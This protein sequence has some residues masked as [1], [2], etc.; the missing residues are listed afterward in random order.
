VSGYR[1][2]RAS[3]PRSKKASAPALLRFEPPVIVQPPLES[4]G[5]GGTSGVLESGCA[6]ASGGGG[7]TGTQVCEEHFMPLAHCVLELHS[8]Q[9]P[10]DASAE[11]SHTV[12][13]AHSVSSAQARH[14]LVE[15]S[16]TGDAP[17]QSPL[18]RQPTHVFVESSHT[19]VLPVHWP[20]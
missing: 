9:L 4:V 10:L 6:P 8:T 2:R 12:P 7:A 3:S 18:A 16:Q 13:V 14:V 1:R 19:V 17:R 15:V 5:A 11:T 20:G